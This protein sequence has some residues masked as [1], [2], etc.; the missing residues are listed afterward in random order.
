MLLQKQNLLQIQSTNQFNTN[1]IAK[2]QG[3]SVRKSSDGDNIDK[4]MMTSGIYMPVFFFTVFMIC[5]SCF[6]APVWALA[7]GSL[8]P[9]G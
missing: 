6:V 4:Y 1:I 7:A 5:A 8:C 2:R 3:C 9:T